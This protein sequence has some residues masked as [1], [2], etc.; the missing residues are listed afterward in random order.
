ESVGIGDKKLREHT[1]V[2]AAASTRP[3]TESPRPDDVA[4][5]DDAVGTFA[6]EADGTSTTS[7]PEIVRSAST[8]TGSSS[9]FQ[10]RH[11]I[12]LLV[13]LALCGTIVLWSHDVGKTLQLARLLR[14]ASPGD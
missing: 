14:R 1:P 11:L 4:Q 9:P 3:S 10:G 13:G 2:L 7:G 5:T 6:R 12:V 8:T